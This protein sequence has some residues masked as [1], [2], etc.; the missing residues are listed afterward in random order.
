MRKALSFRFVRC[1][2]AR[3]ISLLS[4]LFVLLSHSVPGWGQARPPLTLTCDSLTT[5]QAGAG[6]FASLVVSGGTYPYTFSISAGSL[7]SGLGL[8]ASSGWISGIPTAAGI[9][10]FTAMVQDA[11]STQTKNCSIQIAPVITSATTPGAIG[12]STYWID[13]GTDFILTVGGFGFVPGTQILWND[14]PVATTFASATQLSAQIGANLDAIAGTIVIDVI[15]PDGLRPPCPTPPFTQCLWNAVFYVNPVVMSITPAAISQGEEPVT[16]T[17]IGKGFTPGARVHLSPQYAGL[18]SWDVPATYSSPTMLNVVLPTGVN[19]RPGS[20]WF[21]VP[22]DNGMG[23]RQSVPFSVTPCPARLTI[24]SGNGQTGNVN[25]ILASPLVVEATCLK[26]IPAYGVQVYFHVTNAPFGAIV[27]LPAPWALGASPVGSAST[28]VT[29]GD[30]PGEYVVTAYCISC[31]FNVVFT[32]TAVGETTPSPPTNLKATQIGTDGTQI[33]LTWDYGTDQIDGFVIERQKPSDIASD[34]WT[35]LPSLSAQAVQVTPGHWYVRDDG[36]APDPPLTP[37]ATYRYHIQAYK[38]SI[39]SEFVV[40]PPVFQLQLNS[41]NCGIG[42]GHGPCTPL[43]T[44]PSGQGID[45]TIVVVF[46]P[47]PPR[48]LRLSAQAFQYDHFNWISMVKGMPRSVTSLPV[49]MTGFADWQG[50]P[51]SAPPAFWDP[52]LGGP[53]YF[54]SPSS[55]SCGPSGPTADFLPYYWNETIVC[56]GNFLLDFISSD[57]TALAFEDHPHSQYLG[58]TDYFQFA[59][60]LVGVNGP[61]GSASSSTPLTTFTW[62]SN[63]LLAGIGG[64]QGGSS[65]AGTGGVFNVSVVD[66]N[67]LPLDVRT[68]LVQAGVQGISTDPKIDKDAPTT[69]AFLS[70]SQGANGWHASPVTV[71]LIATDIDGPSDIAAT[72]YR[73][74]GGPVIPY[75]APFT[76]S[77]IGTHTIVFGSVD[78][79]LNAENP[80]PSQT[81]TIVAK[82]PTILCTGCYFPINGIRATLAFNAGYIGWVSTFTYNYRTSTQ[83]VQFASTSTSQIAVNGKT[84]TFSGQGTLNGKAGYSFAVTAKDGGAAGSGLDTVSITITGPN[85][86]SYSANGSIAGGDIV[87]NQ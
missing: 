6:Y 72:S 19:V 15:T 55:T 85:N 46:S 56:S 87:V 7:P 79:A 9:F 86:Y 13:A 75:A 2:F 54:H 77:G 63:N 62:S 36:L 48:F 57:G 34:T 33:Q 26:G 11:V 60:T 8:G 83:T 49:S 44:W 42:L 18:E 30:K 41:Q 4:L 51:L 37:Y 82:L 12:P 66:I 32:A 71:N 61:V 59:T 5:G 39:K 16:I 23:S 45:N 74:D 3:T 47:D 67:T 21:V 38:G 69:T 31:D 64:L 73:L 80:L 50:R 1:C 81:F 20:Y 35:T 17:V 70:G 25:S 84:A 52:P 65:G 27:P 10:S 29:L 14:H 68:A 40:S 24:M 78:Q 43:T 76:V 53:D 22:M 58:P 28:Q